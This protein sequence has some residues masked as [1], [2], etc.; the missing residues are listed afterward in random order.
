MNF[1]EAIK[2]ILQHEGGY[3]NH[4]NDKGGETKYGIT[5]RRYPDLDIKNLTKAKAIE[6]YKRDFWDSSRIEVYPDIIRLQM[7]DMSVNMGP[8]SAVK[9]LQR[10]LNRLGYDFLGTGTLGP[11]TMKAVTITPALSL[12]F[13]IGIERLAYYNSIVVNNKS[14]VV[15]LKGWTN[16]T[17]DILKR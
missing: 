13:W 14:Q 4:P 6:L 5:K 15:F 7:F 1:E 12:Y 16:R 17:I 9:V 2:I 10:A 8:K 11:A 3:V